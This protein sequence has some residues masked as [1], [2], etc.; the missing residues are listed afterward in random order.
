MRGIKVARQVPRCGKVKR[1]DGQ[2]CRAP[3]VRGATRCRWHGGLREV[4]NHPGNVRRL[5]GGTYAAQAGYRLR[6]KA[7]GEHWRQLT[8]QEQSFL[9]DL[10]TPEEWAD[11]EQVDFAARHLIEARED[12]WTWQRFLHWRRQRGRP[13]PR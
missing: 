13:A 7:M 8:L 12:L 10:L 5:L 4:P 3:R 9:R 2:P 6:I 11:M 1:S